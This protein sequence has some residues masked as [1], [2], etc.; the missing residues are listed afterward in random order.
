MF[1]MKCPFEY[2]CSIIN[3]SDTNGRILPSE[4]DATISESDGV[5]RC[6]GLDKIN[7]N[8]PFDYDCLYLSSVNAM[9]KDKSVKV[10]TK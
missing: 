1:V 4:L 2:T 6:S 3:G 5:Y 7:E 8:L 10:S 9:M